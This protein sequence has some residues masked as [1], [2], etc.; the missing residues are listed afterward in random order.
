MNK[1]ATCRLSMMVNGRGH[2]LLLL[3]TM[4]Y[5]GAPNDMPCQL[6]SHG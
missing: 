1:K 2:V 6:A 4:I 3:W 5:Q